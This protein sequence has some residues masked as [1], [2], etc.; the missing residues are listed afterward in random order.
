MKVIIAQN[1]NFEGD[2]F[3][4]MWRKEVETNVIPHKGDLIEDSLFKDP[5]EYE[6]IETTINYQENYCY[7]LLKQYENVFPVERKDELKRIAE[8]HDWIAGW[9]NY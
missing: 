6:V 8:L 7:V 4:Y 1:I 5:G 3:P 9:N 2:N